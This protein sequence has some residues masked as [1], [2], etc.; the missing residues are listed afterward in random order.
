MKKLPMFSGLVFITFFTGASHASDLAYKI[1]LK[2]EHTE[3]ATLELEELDWMVGHWQYSALFFGSEIEGLTIVSAAQHDL[4]LGHAHA[5]S[6]EHTAVAEIRSYSQQGKHIDFRVRHVT[7]EL[8]SIE[9]VDAPK[10]HPLIRQEANVYYFDGHTIVK[11]SD[12]QYTL[13]LEVKG[14][15]GRPH[16]FVIPHKRLSQ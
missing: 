7:D 4:M 9:P 12:N 13:Y 11:N 3:R 16:R 5:W 1:L 15:N 10:V 2:E 8:H 14:E 6:D